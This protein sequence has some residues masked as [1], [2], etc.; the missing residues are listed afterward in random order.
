MQPNEKGFHYLKKNCRTY[1]SRNCLVKQILTPPLV[2][3]SDQPHQLQRSMQRKGPRPSGQ[4]EPGFFRSPVAL[5]IVA[6]VAASHQ[7]FPGRT[8]AARPG[9]YMIQRQFRTR[10]SPST[11]LASIS[12]AQQNIFTRK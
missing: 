9:H 6:A 12:V 2:A 8:P 10:K 4:F 3:V 7:V 1:F 5:A 11:K